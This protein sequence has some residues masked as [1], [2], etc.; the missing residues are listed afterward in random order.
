MGS[1]FTRADLTAALPF[2][3]ERHP[4]A[5]AATNVATSGQVSLFTVQGWN[6]GGAPATLVT[7]DRIQVDPWP[8]VVAQVTA[9]SQSYL[10]HVDAWRRDVPTQGG[11]AAVKNLSASISNQTATVVGTS[12]LTIPTLRGRYDVAIFHMGAFDKLLRGTGLSA[13][14][15]AYLDAL[16]F[17]TD[18]TDQKGWF[19]TPISAIIERTFANR[20][21]APPIAWA[22]SVGATTN[23]TPVVTIPALSNQLLVLRNLAAIAPEEAGVTITVDRDDNTGLI[24]LPAHQM[25][26]AG[27]DMFIQ[28][29]HQLTLQIQATTPPVAPI[30][31]RMEVWVLSLSNILR[32][33]L[34]LLTEAGLQRLMG[35]AQGSKFWQDIQV[36]VY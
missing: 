34:G 25:G 22:Q 16:K 33:R 18:P 27:V 17:P 19:P 5:F 7:L 3:Y 6:G 11:W 20:Q 26:R 21:I 14:D 23:E 1:S 13:T 28:A 32:T 10:P 2:W 31:L 24:S 12:G 35:T 30:P 36:G 4:Y 29:E 15:T 8:G 9:D